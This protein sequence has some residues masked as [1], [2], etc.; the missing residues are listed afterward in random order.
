M[1]I[2]RFNLIFLFSFFLLN[3]CVETT[4][5]L[6]PA[7]TVGASGNIYQGGISYTSSQIIEKSTGKATKD[8]IENFFKSKK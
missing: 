1:R 2:N 6:G 7:I 5:L 4:A 3:N 8:H